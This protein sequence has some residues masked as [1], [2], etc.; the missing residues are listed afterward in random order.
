D[1]MS[2]PDPRATRALLTALH[3][4]TE[5]VRLEATVSLGAMGKPGDP[6]MLA[7]VV[8]ALQGQ[9]NFKDKALALWSHV[10]LLALDDKVT[11]QSLAAI[12]KL[13]H[14]PERE[15]RLQCLLAL[16]AMGA[17][18]RTCIPDIIE[19]LDDKEQTVVGAACTALAHMEDHSARLLNGLIKVSERKE[20]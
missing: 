17:K 16:A 6:Q 9:L 3:D 20:P 7:S 14:S 18:A 1:K 19:M 2:G 4:P 8:H 5:R 11:D 12:A 10:S 15:I 13:M